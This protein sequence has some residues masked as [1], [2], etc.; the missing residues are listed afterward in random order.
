MSERRRSE[1]RASGVEIRRVFATDADRARALRLEALS[2]PVAGIAFLETREHAE[3]Q[4]PSF[5]TD[6]TI[7]AA[8]SDSVAQFIAD[9]AGTWVASV[10]V[11]LPEPASVDDFGRVHPEKH[12]LLV[13]VY[14][15]PGHRGTGLLGDLIAAADE[16]ARARGCHAMLLDVHDDNARARAAYERLGFTATG[17]VWAGPHG[18]EVEMVRVSDA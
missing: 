8:L 14:V 11:L 5:W 2:D 16:W 3:S 12:S 9:S 4:P 13:A 15:S 10:T 6:R 17:H 18:P 7:G 1:V